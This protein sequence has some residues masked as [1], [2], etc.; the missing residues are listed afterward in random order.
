MRIA[1]AACRAGE[2]SKDERT[3]TARH[4]PSGIQ[5]GPGVSIH[6]AVKI[7]VPGHLKENGGAFRWFHRLSGVRRTRPL[8]RINVRENTLFF[9]APST[10]AA[11]TSCLAA[12]RLTVGCAPRAARRHPPSTMPQPAWVAGRLQK[13]SAVSRFFYNTILKR[14][15]TYMTAVMIMATA[16]GARVRAGVERLLWP[17][18]RWRGRAERQ[19]SFLHAFH[20]RTAA[21]PPPRRHWLRLCDECDLGL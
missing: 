17:R 10:S 5:E 3:W 21:A 7:K 12:C 19:H 14:S 8:G 11:R 9:A 13:E 1:S 16:T 15:S 4:T 20:S 2:P 6:V 18:H